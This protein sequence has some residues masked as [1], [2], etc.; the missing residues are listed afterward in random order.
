MLLMYKIIQTFD[1]PTTTD[2]LLLLSFA[3]NI[4]PLTIASTSN[5]MT[6]QF[7][8]GPPFN[9]LSLNAIT[10]WCIRS[11]LTKFSVIFSNTHQ[12]KL[13]CLIFIS[14]SGIAQEGNDVFVYIH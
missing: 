10:V 6:I 13:L 9:I 11:H 8:S 3:G 1:G 5:T 4:N 12:S 2:T 7:T 14:I